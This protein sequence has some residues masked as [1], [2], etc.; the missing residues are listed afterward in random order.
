MLLSLIEIGTS[1]RGVGLGVEGVIL[2]AQLV[3]S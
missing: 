2:S 1:G 3:H